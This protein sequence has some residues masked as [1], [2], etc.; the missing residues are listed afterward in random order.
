LA[1]F[2]LSKDKVYCNAS[3]F[4]GK[5]IRITWPHPCD[6]HCHNDC[7]MCKTTIMRKYPQARYTRILIGDS[8]TDFGGAQIAD[9][10]F[11]RSH[12]VEKCEQW[13]IP[14]FRYENF[15]EVIRQLRTFLSKGESMFV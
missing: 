4:S 6:E 10:V 14:Y 12:L 3:D 15:C 5:Q 1:P 13:G 7:G 11:A 2:Q 8:V 9:Y